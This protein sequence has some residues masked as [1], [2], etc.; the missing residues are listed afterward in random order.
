MNYQDSAL[1]CC[2]S[3]A[4]QCLAEV[5]KD[6]TK[7]GHENETSKLRMWVLPHHAGRQPREE[8]HLRPPADR[9]GISLRSGLLSHA[10]KVKV[11]MIDY[12]PINF[13][14]TAGWERL[15]T[16]IFDDPDA[17]ASIEYYC[18]AMLEGHHHQ[19]GPK[20]IVRLVCLLSELRVLRNSLDPSSS[21][22]YK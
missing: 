7:T 4:S 9:F 11:A 21:C 3:D 1:F 15:V 10:G 19:D 13:G 6:S 12:L 14:D 18:C 22:G 8:K 17:T 5:L 20:E 2:R 16:G